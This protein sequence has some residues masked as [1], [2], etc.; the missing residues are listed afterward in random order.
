MTNNN[1]NWERLDSVIR[2]ANMSINYFGRHIGLARSESLY[3]IKSGNN[4][5]SQNL[6][7]RIVEKFPEISLGWLLSGEGSMFSN[8][9]EGKIPFYDCD[10]CGQLLVSDDKPEARC[11]LNL[12]LLEECD[13]AARSY[14][15]AMNSDI[16]AGSIVFLKYTAPEAIIPGGIYVIVCENYV[17]LRKVRPVLTENGMML[18]LEAAVADYDTINISSDEV[19]K[20]YR[21]VG[22]LKLG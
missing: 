12:P 18:M 15:A 7:R 21:V 16:I 22:N 20:M 4:G 2:W 13:L 5:I 8:V 14:D 19:V 6:A 11:W 1:S 3:Q 9:A 17:L 10:V